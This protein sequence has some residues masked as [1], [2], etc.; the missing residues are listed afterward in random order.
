MEIFK[1][2]FLKFYLYKYFI[3]C[4][5]N[6]KFIYWYMYLFMLYIVSLYIGK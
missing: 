3:V 4:V 5:R 2:L 1:I 6:N